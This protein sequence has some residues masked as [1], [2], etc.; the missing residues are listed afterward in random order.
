MAAQ[1]LAVEHAWQKNIVGKLRLARTLRARVDFAKGFADYVEGS[2]VVP[3]LFHQSIHSHK[4]A[5]KAQMD[6]NQKRYE[7]TDLYSF[8]LSFLVPFVPLCGCS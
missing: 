1:D 7:R 5:Q 3:V 4:K 6:F 8:A 2:S